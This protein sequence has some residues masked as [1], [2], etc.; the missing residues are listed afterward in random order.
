MKSVISVLSL[1]F[2]SNLVF[3]HSGHAMSANIGHDIYH[4]LLIILGCVALGTVLK[5]VFPKAKSVKVSNLFR[6]L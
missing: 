3:A 5:L 4:F 1:F 6:R 2:F